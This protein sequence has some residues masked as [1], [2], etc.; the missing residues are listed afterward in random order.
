MKSKLFEDVVIDVMRFVDENEDHMEH[1]PTYGKIGTWH[2]SLR[3]TKEDV[4]YNSDPFTELKAWIDQEMTGPYSM[5]DSAEMGGDNTALYL[6]L[7]DF[8]DA[9]VFYEN[10]EPNRPLHWFVH[11]LMQTFEWFRYEVP[12]NDVFTVSEWTKKNF[13]LA[14]VGVVRDKLCI[15][16]IDKKE[17][18]K[19]FSS[20]LIKNMLVMDSHEQGCQ[21]FISLD[22]YD[23]RNDVISDACADL[24]GSS[25]VK[26]ETD[27]R[28]EYHFSSIDQIKETLAYAALIGGNELRVA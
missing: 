22:Y 14:R 15:I 8:K 3:T 23:D 26:V 6:S 7:I 9:S 27:G 17:V 25:A 16:S 1:H 13:D 10:F 21:H 4:P 5:L 20:Q 11:M 28:V 18:E 24:W 12:C 2:I 19:T